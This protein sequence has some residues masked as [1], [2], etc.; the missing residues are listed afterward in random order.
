MSSTRE[1][2]LKRARSHLQQA[3]LEGLEAARVLL[4]AA[5]RS[6]GLAADASADS[7][8]GN[9]QLSLEDLIAG[10]RKNTPFMLPAALAEPLAAALETEIKRWEQRSQTDPDARLVLRT[11]LGL[12]ELLWELGM[13]REPSSTSQGSPS[14]P[15]S[16]G[17]ARPKRDR[18]QRFDIED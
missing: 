12:R 5:M 3:T 10:L 9:L 16:R 2:A 13:R 17:P 7:W 4:Q 18:V 11:F 15:S 6:R 8:L 14:N 1:E